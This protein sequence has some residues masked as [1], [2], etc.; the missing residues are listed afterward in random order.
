VSYTDQAGQGHEV[1]CAFVAG[2]DG[3]HGVSRASRFYLQCP[4]GDSPDN[5]PDPMA[6]GRLYLVGD[7]AHIITPMGGKGMNLAL[8]DADMLARALRAAGR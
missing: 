6:Y 5:W 4:P 2:C 7:A 8:H 1:T 3:D